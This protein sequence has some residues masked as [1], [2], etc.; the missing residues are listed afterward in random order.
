MVGGLEP[1]EVPDRG[2]HRH[3]NRDVDPRHGHQPSSRPIVQCLDS[4]I[5]VDLGE[6]VAM[7]VQLA[8]QRLDATLLIRWQIL[9]AEPTATDTGEQI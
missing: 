8:Q 3:R 5:M 9:R 1:R 6:L 2:D 4:E 7:E